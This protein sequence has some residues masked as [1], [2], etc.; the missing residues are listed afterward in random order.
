MSID[1][2]VLEVAKNNEPVLKHIGFW[3]SWLR[4]FMKYTRQRKPKKV[5]RLA[6]G[7][8]KDI[9]RSY[10]LFDIYETQQRNNWEDADSV[11]NASIK[12]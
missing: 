6:T 2:A 8:Y 11:Y 4:Y 7:G 5:H 10:D 3:S 12:Q 1:H 9:N